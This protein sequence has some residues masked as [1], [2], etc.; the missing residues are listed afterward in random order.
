M[1]VSCKSDFN[2]KKHLL[3]QTWQILILFLVPSLLHITPLFRLMYL[4]DHVDTTSYPR[5]HLL[6]LRWPQTEHS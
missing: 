4:Y 6:R 5:K 2:K 3:K 1:H